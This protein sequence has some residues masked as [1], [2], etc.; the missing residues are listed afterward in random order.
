MMKKFILENFIKN[1]LITAVLVAAYPLQVVTFKAIDRQYYDS[2]LLAA[3]ILIV[4]A[5]FAV[6]T[7]SYAH[8]DLKVFWQRYLGHVITALIT[9]CTGLLLEA[10]V[11][12]INLIIGFHLWVFDV[13][14]PLFYAS[15]I[16]Y[17][18]WDLFRNATFKSK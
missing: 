8:S 9:L 17:D 12:I 15:L 2:L 5:L 7:Y 10:V 11:I 3:S 6:Y 18:F 1:I 14:A 4:A 16:M 13:V